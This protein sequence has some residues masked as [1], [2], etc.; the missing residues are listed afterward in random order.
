MKGQKGGTWEL[1]G[2]WRKATRLGASENLRKTRG[3]AS[4]MGKLARGFTCQ[5][6]DLNLIPKTHKKVRHNSANI[7][8]LSTEKAKMVNPWSPLAKQ[9]R[10]WA[11]ECPVAHQHL[12]L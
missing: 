12:P 10:D 2:V 5:H 11:V 9:P 8:Y 1:A 6:G 3:R 4:E 7:C